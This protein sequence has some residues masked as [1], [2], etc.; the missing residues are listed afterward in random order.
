[1]KQIAVEKNKDY[2]MDITDQGHEGQGVGR[3]EGFAVFVEGA[4]D[5]ETVEV[6][7]V[8]VEKN[9]AYG[10]LLKIIKEADSRINPVC[11][12]FKRCGG[13]QIQHIDYEKQLSFK[14]KLV[15]E[16][17]HRIGGLENVKVYDAIGMKEPWNY[18]NKAQYPVG[19]I[20][21]KMG[22]GFYA[23]RTHEI[24]Q[25]QDC[26]IQDK[27]SYEIAKHAVEFFGEQKILAYDE[28]TGKGLI[29]HIVV[30]TG[31]KTGE[32]MLVVVANGDSLPKSKEFVDYMKAKN[33][34]ITSIVLNINKKNTNVIL[35]YTN[36]I[37]DGKE[38]ILDK[39]GEYTF[40][41]SPLSFFQVN[42]VQTEVLYS[43]A[44]EYAALTGKETVFDLYSG[45]GTISL[46]LSGKAK[47][48]YGIE[49]VEPAVDNAKENARINGI[50]NV[51]FLCGDV[52]KVV[53]G[54]GVKPDVV[55]LDPPRKGCEKMLIETI[56]EMGPKRIV[57]VSCNPSTLA[58]DLKAFAEKGYEA[59]E[60]Q[61][62]DM[63]PQTY[64]VE[65]V[66]LIERK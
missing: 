31:F 40:K 42:P 5:G 66:V 1:M 13:C 29:R 46:F 8:K 36:K 55:V 51:E 39:L 24:I 57:Y 2:I 10:K 56:A 58:R 22:F 61:P 7:I 17:I 52:E 23:S 3:I 30:R 33:P 35:G 28:K 27:K 37:L 25:G 20:D 64:H 11:P 44:V 15:S 6:K 48:V 34:E 9:F 60:V 19:N 65:C 62:V 32:I 59:K 26:I 49:V 21:G 50:D 16:T 14:T 63:F 45:I 47:K 53:P 41:I 38:Y 18:R 54:L 4:V 12:V 43:K